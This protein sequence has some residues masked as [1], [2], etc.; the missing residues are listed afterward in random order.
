M[1]QRSGASF[2]SGCRQDET[3]RGRILSRRLGSLAAPFLTAVGVAVFAPD[4]EA[5]GGC[6]APPQDATIV[7]GHRMAFAVSGDRT[8]LWDQFQYSGPA[9]DFSWV[10]PIRPGA[11]IETSTDAWFEALEAAT[12]T[13]VTA[14]QIFCGG[15]S[16]SSGCDGCG[17]YSDETTGG[18][19]NDGA[20]G[21]GGVDVI[22][23]ETVGPY[24]TVTLRSED[25]EALRT[26][27][28]EHGYAVPKA[29]EPIIDA[30]VAEKHDF[31]ALRLSP[32]ESVTRMTPVR[33]VTEGGPSLLPLRMVAAGVADDV[34]ITLFIL[35]EGRYAMP[36]L[37]EVL[38]D[39][40][41]LVW[42]F[43]AFDPS[44]AHNY[45]DLRDELLRQNDGKVHLTTFALDAEAFEERQSNQGNWQATNFSGLADDYFARAAENDDVANICGDYS[46]EFASSELVRRDAMGSGE[47]DSSVFLCREWSD[48]E[49]AM[50][51]LHPSRL[52]ITRLEM[53]LPKSALT[54]DCRVELAKAQ[55]T[56][57]SDLVATRAENSPCP[58]AVR[59]PTSVPAVISG[60]FLGAFLRRRRRRT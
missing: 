13:T 26:W 20:G 31:I 35:G 9:E 49:A 46:D 25:P 50:I 44:R 34:D 2:V 11:T 10:L 5:C 43:S 60:V 23:E 29:V 40:D 52:W 3:S 1:R 6:F 21:G 30:Y 56:V 15:F 48:I 19:S 18:G 54:I 58:T 41:K 55:A 47:L 37:E 12:Q 53:R 39:P 4:A 33:V 45:L 38:V 51:G 42:D 57:S 17:G 59:V 27:L 28:S 32:G 7:T 22:H 16:D 14:P 8:V 36:D 24:D